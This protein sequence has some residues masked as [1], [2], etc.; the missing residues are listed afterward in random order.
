M[1]KKIIW[2][3]T[4]M[5]VDKLAGWLTIHNLHPSKVRLTALTKN[6]VLVVYVDK[7]IPND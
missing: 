6:T 5:P 1:P 2:K 3:Q 7:Q 4:V